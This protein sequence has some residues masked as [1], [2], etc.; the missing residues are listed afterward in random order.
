M[1]VAGLLSFEARADNADM[2]VQDDDGFLLYEYR[3]I[4]RY[5]V[6]KYATQ[7]PALIP[8]GLRAVALFEQAASVERNNFFP[9]IYNIFIEKITKPCGIPANAGGSRTHGGSQYTLTTGNSQLWASG[10]VSRLVGKSVRE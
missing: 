6:T 2:D 5:I 3:A 8:T 10:W 1:P 4:A 9:P 7:G